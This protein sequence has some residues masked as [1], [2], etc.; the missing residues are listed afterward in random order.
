LNDEELLKPQLSNYLLKERGVQH[1]RHIKCVFV[2]LL[3]VAV[4]VVSNYV[5]LLLFVFDYLMLD[6]M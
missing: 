1:Q 2:C 5:G 4:V 6:V 3:F